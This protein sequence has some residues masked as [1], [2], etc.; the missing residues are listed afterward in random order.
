M[1]GHKCQHVSMDS[2]T[3]HLGDTRTKH[4]WTQI[5]EC[6]VYGFRW[7]CTHRDPETNNINPQ[8]GDR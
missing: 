5:R 2:D 1:H 4:T 8:A 6:M 7:D 3:G